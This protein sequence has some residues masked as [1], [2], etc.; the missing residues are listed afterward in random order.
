MH[1]VRRLVI[2]LEVVPVVLEVQEVRISKVVLQRL[3]QAVRHQRH[4][5]VRLFKGNPPAV[6]F[7][8]WGKWPLNKRKM[9]FGKRNL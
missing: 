8:T 1:L 3:A 2:L 6:S 5:A 7:S 9:P 4:Q